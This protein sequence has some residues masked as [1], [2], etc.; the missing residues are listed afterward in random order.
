MGAHAREQR[1]RA[2]RAE[3]NLRCGRE[4][5]RVEQEAPL[6]FAPDASPPAGSA[7]EPRRAR[8]FTLIEILT[9]IAII[10]VL[11]GITLGAA[12]G[13]KQRAA[14]AQA[15]AE[16]AVLATALESYKRQYGDYPWTG[17][18]AN[19][20]LLSAPLAE[21][22]PGILFNALAGKRGP[23]EDLTAMD[24]KTW[25][26]FGRLT[27][28][29]PTKLPE[30]GSTGQ[31]ANAFVDPWGRR[32][33]YFYNPSTAWKAVGY[34]LYSVGPDGAKAETPAECHKAPDPDSGA[35]DAAETA[36]ADNLYANQ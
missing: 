26:D 1:W 31:L 28:Q 8:A 14:M 2:G 25:V 10:A 35:Y 16:L 13:V 27:V 17:T 6:M 5:E 7:R 33:L 20:P 32:Y 3:W 9:V 29:D 24:G 21:D 18:A 4:G 22:G 15:K 34:V 36:N 12:R 23:L 30:H 19:D 11:A